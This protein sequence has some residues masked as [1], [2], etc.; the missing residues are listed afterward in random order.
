M[1][2]FKNDVSVEGFANELL[3]GGECPSGNCGL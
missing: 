3:Y 1:I 2:G